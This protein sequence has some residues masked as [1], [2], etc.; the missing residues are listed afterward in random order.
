ML[1]GFNA[2]T[3]VGSIQ[4]VVFETSSVSLQITGDIQIYQNGALSIDGF[5]N[6]QTMQNCYIY[7]RVQRA[8]RVADNLAW[9]CA[10]ESAVTAKQSVGACHPSSG[11]VGAVVQ[12]VAESQGDPA[13]RVFALCFSLI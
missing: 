8:S 13:L 4:S 1:S 11:L 9:S 3:T 2:L 5:Y 12:Q 7:V 10:G 6:V